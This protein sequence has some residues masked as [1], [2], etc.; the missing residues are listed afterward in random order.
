MSAS[1]DYR[2]S[3]MLALANCETIEEVDLMELMTADDRFT[4]EGEDCAALVDA[5]TVYAE[6]EA[7]DYGCMLELCTASEKTERAQQ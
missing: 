2:L 5:F 4:A 6:H 3:R 1:Q 7:R